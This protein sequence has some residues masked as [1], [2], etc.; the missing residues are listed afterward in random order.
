MRVG[1]ECV[2]RVR[3]S[4]PACSLENT[5]AVICASVANTRPC[6]LE[7]EL[8][9]IPGSTRPY[10]REHVHGMRTDVL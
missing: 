1:T 6:A 5:S 3:M 4:A 9:D 8:H 10:T 7:Y 2:D